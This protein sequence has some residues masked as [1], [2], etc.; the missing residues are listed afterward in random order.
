[1]LRSQWKN[2]WLWSSTRNNWIFIGIVAAS[3]EEFDAAT[4]KYRKLFK[5]T[6]REQFDD[7]EY[8]KKLA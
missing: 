3:L 2:E 8:A 5:R 4:T 1:M 6:L 7:S